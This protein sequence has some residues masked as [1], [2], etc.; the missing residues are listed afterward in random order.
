MF[1]ML[2]ISTE[3]LKFFPKSLIFLTR[4]LVFWPESKKDKTTKILKI[5]SEILNISTKILEIFTE[6]LEILTKMFDTIFTSDF[7]TKNL[8]SKWKHTFKN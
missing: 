2:E 7:S 3:M 6:L 5:S 8:N 4:I 1:K